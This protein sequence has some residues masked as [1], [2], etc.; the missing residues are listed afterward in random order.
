MNRFLKPLLF[1]G[2]VAAMLPG[3]S[4]GPES[5]PAEKEQL[6]RAEWPQ[7]RGPTGMG[8]SSEEGLPA[9]W[10]AESANV[11][12]R[13]SIPGSGNSSPVVSHGRVFLSTAYAAPGDDSQLRRECLAVDFETG[14]L[15]WKTPIV[16][17]AE[18]IQHRL[19]TGAGPTP[20]TDGE[21]VFFYFGSVLA[22][23]DLEGRVL[24]KNEVDPRY[25]E[26]SRYAAASSPVLAG[27]A[28]VVVQD[29]EWADTEDKGWMAAFD[30]KTGRQIWRR[31]WRDTC[32]SYSTPLVVEQESGPR[33]FFAH[34]GSVAEYDLLSGERLWSRAI[35][36]SQM[37]SSLVFEKDLLCIAGGAHHVRIATCLRLTGS[38]PETRA[39]SLW[40]T[41]RR[42][43]ETS[44]PVLYGGQLFTVSNN[45]IF[46]SFDS[47]SGELLWGHRLRQGRY[48]ASLVAGDG[49]VYAFNSRG[50]TTVIAVEPRL[51]ILAENALD[52]GGSA[53]PALV[54]GS[55]LVRTESQLVR[56]VRE[57]G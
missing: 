39:E 20:A 40:E 2:A 29:R 22:A 43:P 53:S 57:E 52:E 33:L 13:L 38:G 3:C 19:S 41:T 36:A 7:W 25:A 26:F 35:E 9:K 27:G 4:D 44:S 46:S 24:W 10:S 47:E 37:V 11:K 32:C 50:L 34:S 12:W 15:L 48:N 56:I 49:K 54:G 5:A 16:T 14:E 8:L 17:A 30:K 31:E 6:P 51:E 55:I 45:G 18:E 1:L 42:T 28:V 23:L 21:H